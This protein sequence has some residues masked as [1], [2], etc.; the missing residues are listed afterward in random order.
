M[1][2]YSDWNTARFDLVVKAL[3]GNPNNPRDRLYAYKLGPIGA[4]SAEAAA[5][6]R[7]NWDRSH[8]DYDNEVGD[9]AIYARMILNDLKS[10]TLGEVKTETALSISD[11]PGTTAI[12]LLHTQRIASRLLSTGKSLIV[13]VPHPFTGT[14]A[15]KPEDLNLT[16]YTPIYRTFCPTLEQ[17]RCYRVSSGDMNPAHDDPEYM[18]RTQFGK[19]IV[20]G[21]QVTGWCVIQG[22]D[23]LQPL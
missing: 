19:I 4:V 23:S 7:C 10:A 16:G 13:M 3:G 20:Y 8:I 5:M 15:D 1:P 6:A 2:L 12:W 9:V 18:K 22:L 21:Q 14:R 17:V 11:K